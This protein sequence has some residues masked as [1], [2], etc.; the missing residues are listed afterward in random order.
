MIEEILSSA[1][2][3][4]VIMGPFASIPV[5]ISVTKGMNPK[6]RVSAATQAIGMAAVVLFAF[7]LFGQYILQVFLIDFNSLKIAGG[8]VLTILGIELVLGVFLVGKHRYSPAIALLGCPL[9]TGP[10]VIVTTMIF[11]QTYGHFITAVAAAIS[12][13]AS[14]AVLWFSNRIRSALGSYWIETVSRVTGLLLAA[15]AIAL[16]INGVKAALAAP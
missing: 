6:Q 8:I 9:L 11:V 12:L 1:L 14:W 7:L 2:S 10:G 15:L 4:F 13:A 5:F 3:L 16:I